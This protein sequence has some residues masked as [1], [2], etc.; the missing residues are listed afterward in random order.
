M[1]DDMDTD[2]IYFEPIPDS[3]LMRNFK[4]GRPR[5][6]R[7]DGVVQTAYDT[8]C[9]QQAVIPNWKVDDLVRGIKRSARHLGI[10]VSYT[11]SVN[12]ED[13]EQVIFEFIAYPTNKRNSET[14]SEGECDVEASGEWPVVE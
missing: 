8:R 11:G 9:A 5:D 6:T 14:S 1:N 13:S 12:P 2:I 4:M 7:Y 10:S 3:A